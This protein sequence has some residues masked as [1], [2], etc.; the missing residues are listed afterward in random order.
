MA[1]MDL[2]RLIRKYWV[3]VLVAALVCGAAG[4]AF[5]MIKHDAKDQISA[6]ANIVGNSQT[7]GV[8]GF[9]LAESRKVVF[10]DGIRFEDGECEYELAVEVESGSQTVKV[11]V[12]G[13][14]KALCID[15][16]NQIAEAACSKAKAEYPG[17][18]YLLAYRGQVEKATM[19]N[20]E[21][22]AG[23][24][25]KL[26]IAAILA[27][28]FLGICIVVIID[29]IRRPIK[30]GEGM[31]A[32]VELPVLEKLPS[33]NGERLLANVRFAAKTDDLK[34]V[35]VVPLGE[36]DLAEQVADL[37]RAA[38]EV[39]HSVG[40]GMSQEVDDT[41]RDTFYVQACEP[42]SAG[43]SAAYESRGADAVIIAG[44]QWKDGLVVLE[45]TVAELKLAEANLVGLVFAQ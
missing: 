3:I 12:S 13:P 45:A 15:T 25:M 30:S 38:I 27:G 10:A 37:M 14:D 19:A 28:L 29:M 17:S 21:E 1:L 34:R 6:T 43:M 39:E 40:K 11:T 7:G 33:L 8:K 22:A 18:D 35:C 44:R 36:G 24:S 20:V 42:L 26:L 9:A 31:Q 23:P 41:V 2:F 4:F 16:A 32:A 5:S